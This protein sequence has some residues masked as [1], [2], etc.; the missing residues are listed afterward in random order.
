M[1]QRKRASGNGLGKKMRTHFITGFL[2]LVPIA[3]TILLLVWVFTTI[4][5]ILQ[6][7]IML[8]FGRTIP[9]VG[10]GVTV[11]LIYLVGV[12]TGNVVGK[13]L[14]HYGETLLVAKIPVVRP[15]YNTVKQILESFSTRR[16]AEFIQVVF[17]E[18]PRKG[19]W[20]IGF[21]TNESLS[22]SGEKLLNIFVP[23]APN[24]MS[25]FLQITKEEEVTRTNIPINEAMKMIISAGKVSAKEM[26]DIRENLPIEN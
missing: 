22:K 5:N 1:K 14:L 7:L 23:T 2:V 20:T 3:A 16:S 18:F 15:L 21:I 19:I 25:G 6:P 10:F 12:I 4:D 11:V 8:I 24:P 9:G 13:R 26:G 17:I